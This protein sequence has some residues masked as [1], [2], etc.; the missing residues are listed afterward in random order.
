MLS[1]DLL[2]LRIEN[3]SSLLVSR[4]RWCSYYVLPF[5][6]WKY[7]ELESIHGW[8][9]RWFF[10]FFIWIEFFHIKPLPLH[11]YSSSN[12]LTI[13]FLTYL[14]VNHF[15]TYSAHLLTSSSFQ[16]KNNHKTSILLKLNKRRIISDKVKL[17]HIIF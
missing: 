17:C 2:L 8:T 3:M 13:T 9:Q 16:K 10:N 14:W 5:R 11:S 6:P 7:I 4:M 15:I 12:F 1:E